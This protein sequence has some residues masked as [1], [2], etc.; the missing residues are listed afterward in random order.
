[1][2]LNKNRGLKTQL[3]LS[4][5]YSQKKGMLGDWISFFNSIQTFLIPLVTYSIQTFFTFS[6]F[7]IAIKFCQYMLYFKE[8][9]FQKSFVIQERYSKQKVHWKV[10]TSQYHEHNMNKDTKFDIYTENRNAGMLSYFYFK[11]DVVW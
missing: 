7:I 2:G 11:S 10:A 8:G 9:K 3:F 1:M 5:R 6:L 4:S